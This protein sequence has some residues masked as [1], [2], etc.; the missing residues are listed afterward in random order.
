MRKIINKDNGKVLCVYEHIIVTNHW[1]Y[2]V[3]EDKQKGD[4]RLCLTY[5]YENEIGEVSL[6][7]IRPYIRSRTTDLSELMPPPGWNWED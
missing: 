4:L 2:Y 7:E 3:C 6:N 5:G 1:E